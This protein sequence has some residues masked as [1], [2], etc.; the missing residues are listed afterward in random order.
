MLSSLLSL[1]LLGLDI[2][3]VGVVVVRVGIMVY[4]LMFALTIDVAIVHGDDDD[5]LLTFVLF[6][7]LL[8]FW[9]LLL[10]CVCL[11]VCSLMF[12]RFFIKVGLQQAL[13]CLQ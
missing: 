12:L 8:L 10:R 6:L 7:F 9:F 11:F 3:L 5:V 4:C 1:L 13:P 2:V